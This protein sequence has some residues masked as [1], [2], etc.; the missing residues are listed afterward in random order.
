MVSYVLRRVLHALLVTFIVSIIVFLL[1]RAL[2]GDPIQSI[3]MSDMYTVYTPE[4]IEELKE[5]MGLGGNFVQQ[6]I[7]W[8]S[9]IIRG[10]FGKSLL[11]GSKVGPQVASRLI[12]T[13]VIGMT[14]FVV[15]IVLGPTLGIISA[16]KRGKWLD[17]VVTV[18]ANI[19]ITAPTFWLAILF[20]F[21]FSVKL[22]WLP[23][24]GY[25]LPWV[26]FGMSVKQS[27]LP[28]IVTA[29]M[30][31]AS[32]ARQMRSSVLEVLGED[33]VRTAW[34]KGL[35][36]RKVLLKH[37]L[38]NSLMPIVTLQGH[39]LRMIVGGSVVV[40]TIF[41]IPGMG[42]YMVEAM[43]GQDYT[44]VQGV[45]VIMTLIVVLINLTVDLLYVW[46]DPRIQYGKGGAA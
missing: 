20:M 13:L 14:A 42:K 2:P 40:E 15:G 39:N 23:I 30:P 1:V 9:H 5:E 36:E 37:V 44:I 31:I 18:F 29:F 33:Y 11:Y 35:N 32:S 6:Y 16:V 24:Y 25:T 7:T 41:V 26:D 4:M 46:I 28:V 43:L 34:A 3:I 10:D 12:V 22:H 8:G 21:A 45:T 27:I 38:K 19:G 17:D